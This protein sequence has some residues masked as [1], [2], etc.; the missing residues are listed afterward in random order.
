[1]KFVLVDSSLVDFAGHHYEYAQH[2]LDAASRAGFEPH[3][4]A[5]RHF[6]PILARWPTQP[7]YKYGYWF[8][9]GAPAWQRSVYAKAAGSRSQRD[10]GHG[11]LW[12]LGKLPQSGAA[13]AFIAASRRRHFVRDTR[14]AIARLGVGQGD[15]I[16]L[17]S[18]SPNELIALERFLRTSART[19]SA[20]WHVV[21]RRDVPA[22]RTW[23]L[24]RHAV[25]RLVEVRCPARVHFWTDS[26]ALSSAYE[27]ATGCRFGTL[28]IPHAC[29]ADARRQ[30]GG[31]CQVVY[32]GDARSEK[33]FHHLPRIVR[34]LTSDDGRRGRFTFRFQSYTSMPVAE[35]QVVA[36]RIELEK[37]APRGVVLIDVALVPT[38]YRRLLAES[39][40]TLLPY[41]PAA[42]AS[43]SSGVFADSLAAGVRVVV[44]EGTWMAR[45]LPRGSGRTYRSL[46]DVP[47][48]VRELARESNAETDPPPA[49]VAQW[50]EAHNADRLVAQLADESQLTTDH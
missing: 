1:M 28:P 6:T 35:S 32:L 18:L 10:P 26:D 23:P 24:V 15:L 39:H 13:R 45:Q 29:Q 21:L 43:R 40:V 48:L 5:N 30:G 7:A 11:L 46:A 50:R 2:V 25:R 47:A 8:H 19:G 49:W 44:P 34:E 20:Q 38:A 31:A 36:A 4:V 3:L 33:G 22:G 14:D 16:F 37:L 41:E 42:Y 12:K 17:P 9:Q 27:R